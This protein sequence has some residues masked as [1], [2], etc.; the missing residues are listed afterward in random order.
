[1]QIE[2]LLEKFGSLESKLIDLD[3]KLESRNNELIE[4]ARVGA[5]ITSI[6]DLDGILSA[7]LEMSLRLLHAEVGCILTWEKGVEPVTKISWGIDYSLVRMLKLEGEMD[8]AQWTKGSGETVII[9][10]FPPEME[11]PAEVNSVISAP[12]NCRGKTI[13][14]LIAVNKTEGDGFNADDKAMLEMLVN[15]ASVA[16]ENS[17]LMEERL[18][19]QKLEDELALA[20]EVQNALLPTNEFDFEGAGISHIY[21]PAGQVGGD[22]YD[23]IPISPKEFVLIVGDVSNKGVPAALM[24]TAVRS[25]VRNEVRSKR[26]VALIMNNINLTLCQD[27]MRREGMFITLFFAYINLETKEMVCSNAGHL[28]PLLFNPGRE[29]IIQLKRGGLILGQFEE[30]EYSAEKVGLH[31]GDR[32]LCFTDGVTECENSHGDMYGREGIQEFATRHKNLDQDR[33]LEL[34]KT[35][36]DEYAAGPGKIQF[37]DITCVLVGIK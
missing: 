11:I 20:K 1:M 18:V 7:M 30:Y 26:D 4:M 2:G 6:L 13:G 33:F 32:I 12:L 15:F 34:L 29:E 5:M 9:N 36:I 28:P 8:I 22:Y 17:K 25:V 19:K 21:Y 14:V 31:K 27:V 3:L 23:I 35:E 10:D 24:M 37:D 16:I